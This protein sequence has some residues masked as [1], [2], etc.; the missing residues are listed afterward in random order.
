M[1]MVSRWFAFA[2]LVVASGL[3][4]WV[5]QHCGKQSP[6]AGRYFASHAGQCNR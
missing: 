6:S 1:R 4:G 2:G 3:I 5:A